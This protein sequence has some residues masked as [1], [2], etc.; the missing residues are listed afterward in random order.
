M[1]GEAKDA[2]DQVGERF[3]DLGRK[4]SDHY[5]RQEGA[6]SQS[7]D[8]AKRKID[9][10]IRTVGEHVDRAFTS[11]GESIRDPETKDTAQ[12]AVRSLGDALDK[13]FADV[14]EAIRRRLDRGGSSGQA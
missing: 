2:W 12:K 13:T 11:L 14:S 1:A 9:D 7:A 5:K 3:A 8:E 6:T 10:A 4:L